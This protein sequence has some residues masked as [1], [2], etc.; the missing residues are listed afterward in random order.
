M[1]SIGQRAAASAEVIPLLPG[2]VRKMTFSLRNI[3]LQ[4]VSWAALRTSPRTRWRCAGLAWP[5]EAC[6]SGAPIR[7]KVSPVGNSKDSI[8]AYRNVR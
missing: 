6:G 2:S 8:S 5:G 7:I 3:A 4:L 1:T